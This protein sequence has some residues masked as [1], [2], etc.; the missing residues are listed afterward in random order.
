MDEK[1][2]IWFSY[3][4]A[5]DFEPN[6]SSEDDEETIAKEEGDAGQTN[7]SDEIERLKQESELP[8]EDLLKDLPEDY[9]NERDKNGPSEGNNQ[10]VGFCKFLF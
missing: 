6:T 2:E 9:W 7:N 8:L 5:D 3:F 1:L 10:E 4:V